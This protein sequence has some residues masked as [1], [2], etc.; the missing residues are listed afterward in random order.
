MREIRD[1]IRSIIFGAVA[2]LTILLLLRFTFIIINVQNT[3]PI[4]QA[5][6]GLS[7]PLMTPFAGMPNAL[8][9]FGAGSI[10][11]SILIAI[12]VYVAAALLFVGIMNAF[13]QEDIFNIF[14]EVTDLMF[15]FVEFILII[16]I[17]FRFFGIQP[18]QVPFASTIYDWTFWSRGLIG[19]LTLG[20]IKV[21]LSMIMVLVIVIAFDLTFESLAERARVRIVKRVVKTETKVEA[22]APAPPAPAPAPQV[23]VAPMPVA[24]AAAPAAPNNITINVPVPTPMMAP[25]PITVQPNQPQRQVINVSLPSASKPK[26]E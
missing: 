7:D 22:K 24:P 16:G 26:T 17:I 2:L 25:P 10:D 6:Y 23:V 15:K 19:E 1:I 8:I 3:H 4:A 14:L 20:N 18:G 12:G 11:L 9:S 13:L 5:I 21:D